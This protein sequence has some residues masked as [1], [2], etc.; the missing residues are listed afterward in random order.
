LKATR[1]VEIALLFALGAV[2]FADAGS[3][4]ARNADLPAGRLVVDFTSDHDP[5]ETPLDAAN[6]DYAQTPRSWGDRAAA[7]ISDFSG[8][9]QIG[10][11]AEQGPYAG[12][13]R[14]SQSLL[15]GLTDPEGMPDDP[16]APK[17]GTIPSP[18]LTADEYNPKYGPIGPDGKQVSIG[19]EPM[20]EGVAQ[21]IGRAKAAEIE[22]NGVLA[23]Y[24]RQHPV[25]SFV[26]GIPAFL[27]DPINLVMTIVF[28]ALASWAWASIKRALRRDAEVRASSR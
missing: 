21:A 26:T 10:D 16:D 8:V 3:S 17:P 6:E 4:G 7:Q 20:P 19:T 2:R 11:I 22:R 25:L 14:L 15:Y 28:S 1:V 5:F 13:S 27:M 18:T 23:Q 9:R 12:S 24:S